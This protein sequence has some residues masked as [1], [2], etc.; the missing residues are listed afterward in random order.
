[1]NG[2]SE[3]DMKG[4]IVR[5]DPKY[6][7]RFY[8]GVKTTRIYC[9]PICPARPKPENI[10]IFKSSSEAERNGYRP[11]KRC[12]PDLSPGA[13]VLD[14]KY[15]AVSKALHHIE[16]NTEDLSVENLAHVL[17][18]TSR[19]LRRL[20]DEYLGVS[21][22]DVINTKRLHLAKQLL[23]ETKCPI[24]EIGLAVGFNSIR[25]F[26]EAF[27]ALYKEPPSEF[28]K[29]KASINQD[30]G[31]IT[32]K[33]PVHQPYD[34]D[35]VIDYLNRHLIP[36]TERV[37]DNCYIRHIPVSRDTLGR[38]IV[39]MADD[40]KALQ[41]VLSQIPLSL[42]QT[43][44][45]NVKKLFDTDHNPSHLTQEKILN[46]GIRTPGSYDAFEVAVSI[47]LS[48]LI[49]TEQAKKKLN[50]LAILFGTSVKSDLFESE[51]ILFPS[52]KVLAVSE[53]EKIGIS[54]V[55]ASAI[56][57]LARQVDSEGLKLSYLENIDQVRERLSLIK[58][59]G[60]WTV[61]LIAMRCLGDSNAFPKSDLIVKRALDMRLMSEKPWA[62]AQAY[63]CH[64]IWRDLAAHLRRL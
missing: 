50:Q 23:L 24:T 15:L 62:G 37:V 47:I 54:K 10:L 26:N 16:D 12:K 22:I 36:G 42:V 43:I 29:S 57:E 25:R 52:A 31:Q 13:K 64:V 49:S 30:T 33:I 3:T 40:R 18:I 46:K 38:I 61:E 45:F 6:D 34:W 4:L 53:I 48:Q 8:F 56:R 17:N 59:I 7:G 60:P 11:C 5:R 9:R 44:L 55:K 20:F 32:L 35:Y 41:V 21:P 1:M 58:G 19:H 14:L 63:L 2:L 27:K 51:I 39:K 28:R